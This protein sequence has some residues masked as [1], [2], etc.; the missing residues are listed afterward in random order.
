[1]KKLI[2]ANFKMNIFHNEI[3]WYFEKFN[4]LYQ[5]DENKDVV[6]TPMFTSIEKTAN[7]LKDCQLWAQNVWLEDSW[8][9][10]S[11]VSPLELKQLCCTYCIVWHSESR[12]YL[13]EIDEEINQKIKKLLEHWIR[14]ILCV[15][16]SLEDFEEDKWLE[17]V[18][19]QV[20]YAIQWI[21]AS[22]ID[23]AYE[24]LW[25][26]W[27]WKSADWAYADKIHT[28][29]R[30]II[31]NQESR[32]IY[33]WSVKPENVEEFSKYES[34]NW[35]LVGSAALDPEKFLQIIEKS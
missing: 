12:E 26:I 7:L 4:E 8:A 20:K 23:I 30:N 10:T 11:Q 16:E 33:W 14:P 28:H 25:A 24:P 5:A 17:K 18:E 15:W 22:K 21:D 34:I 9:Y 31:W 3:D 2:W 6:F 32:I 13:A 35:F 29:I 27:T 1:M 19:Q